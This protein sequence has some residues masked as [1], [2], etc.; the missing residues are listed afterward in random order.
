M[1]EVDL[2]VNS[3]E[4]TANDAAVLYELRSS[5]VSDDDVKKVMRDNALDL[6][7]ANVGAPA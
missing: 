7:G 2:S 5:G 3:A 1:A 6:L 4:V